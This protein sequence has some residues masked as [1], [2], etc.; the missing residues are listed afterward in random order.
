MLTHGNINQRKTHVGGS[1]YLVLSKCLLGILLSVVEQNGD[2]N[3]FQVV[4]DTI[5][6]LIMPIG[7]TSH[8]HGYME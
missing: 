5:L 7:F 6:K 4:T 1:R 2:I 3:K 8:V